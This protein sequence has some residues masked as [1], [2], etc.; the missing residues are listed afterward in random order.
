MDYIRTGSLYTFLHSSDCWCLHAGQGPDV[1]TSDA[2]SG[3]PG[4]LQGAG[5]RIYVGGIPNAVSETM[6]RNYFSNWGKVSFC[7]H[8]LGIEDATIHGWLAVSIACP[9]AFL[10][11][12]VVCWLLA[13]CGIV[14]FAW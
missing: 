4:V 1:G 5:P 8:C 9:L 14:S 2:G 6:V 7:W 3:R 10:H 11:A 13:A 12:T